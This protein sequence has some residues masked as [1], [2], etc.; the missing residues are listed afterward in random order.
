MIKQ[1]TPTDVQAFLIPEP[2]DIPEDFDGRHATLWPYVEAE[3]HGGRLALNDQIIFG[4]PSRIGYVLSAKG[5]GDA[6]ELLVADWLYIHTNDF[7]YF[8]ITLDEVHVVC[9]RKGHIFDVSA[10]ATYLN[11]SEEWIR[12]Q[13]RKSNL[14]SVLNVRTGK[15]MMTRRMLDQF[16]VDGR[17][18]NG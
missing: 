14:S 16:I 15:H 8:I 18:P 17:T 5:D 9:D 3:A 13:I 6:T 11:V 7:K 2:I 4:T 10:A 1:A 12:E